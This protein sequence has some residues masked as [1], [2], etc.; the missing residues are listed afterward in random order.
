MMDWNC[1]KDEIGNPKRK[2]GHGS[3]PESPHLRMSLLGDATI[4]VACTF[5][6]RADTVVVHLNQFTDWINPDID[7]LGICVPGVRDGLRENCGIRTEHRGL[8]NLSLSRIE[9][10][11]E[12]RWLARRAVGTVRRPIGPAVRILAIPGCTKCRN[13]EPICCRVHCAAVRTRLSVR[14]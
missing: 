1:H 12:E 13:G 11:A 14:S 2:F 6:R 8:R 7:I 9:V 10:E 3:H 5:D 4:L